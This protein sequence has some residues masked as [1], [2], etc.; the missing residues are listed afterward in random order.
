MGLRTIHSR[1]I[2]RRD[3]GDQNASANH[4]LQVNREQFGF[5]RELPEQSADGWC[6]TRRSVGK[7][8][9]LRE[10]MSMESM[11]GEAEDLPSKGA[12]RSELA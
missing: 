8:R 6:S 3:R 11:S 9:V 10:S 1:H 4:E 2:R 12:A 7:Q 5:V